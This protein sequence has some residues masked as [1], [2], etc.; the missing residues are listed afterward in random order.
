MGDFAADLDPDAALSRVP[1][2]RGQR[3]NSKGISCATG[4][5][6]RFWFSAR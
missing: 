5:S 4:A 2:Y 3:P 1:A 6:Q